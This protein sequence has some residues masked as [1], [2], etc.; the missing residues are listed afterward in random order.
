MERINKP[1]INTLLISIYLAMLGDFLLTISSFWWLKIAYDKGYSAILP[2]NE[3][4]LWNAVPSGTYPFMLFF[5]V[6]C[7]VI[8]F[9]ALFEG[10]KIINNIKNSK[11]FCINN[12]NSFK[13]TSVY[14]FIL[15]LLFGL[16]MFFS[17]SLLTLICCGLLFAGTLLLG[18]LSQLFKQAYEIKQ[19][20]ELTI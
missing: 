2:I 19:E 8:I 20:N 13:R 17:A 16:K 3:D 11:P 18:V 4:Y 7:G 9:F 6:F 10:G 5:I 15:C 1:L 14:S 12:A